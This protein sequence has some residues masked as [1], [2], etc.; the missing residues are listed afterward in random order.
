[1]L[2][3]QVSTPQQQELKTMH[4][5][6]ASHA[7]NSV[8]RNTLNARSALLPQNYPIPRDVMQ[9]LL[10]APLLRSCPPLQHHVYGHYLRNFWIL[11]AGGI[12]GSWEV[13]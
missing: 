11:K 7:F 3:Y 1:M 10:S 2:V 12:G 9:H 4:R 5:W 13:R 8:L 6:L